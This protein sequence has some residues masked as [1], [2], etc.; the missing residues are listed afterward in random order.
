MRHLGTVMS[1]DSK[2]GL[3]SIQTGHGNEEIDFERGAVMWRRSIDPAPG[4][5]LSYEVKIS[6][7]RLR[8]G[9][10]AERPRDDT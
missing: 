2:L 3:G 9:K 1:F 6:D 10:P 5:V 4:Q 8:G 7:G